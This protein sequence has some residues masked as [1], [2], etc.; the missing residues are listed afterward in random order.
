MSMFRMVTLVGL[1]MGVAA[2]AW[3]DGPAGE[4]CAAKLNGD[5]KAVYAATM[6]AKP[7]KETLRETVE[8]EARGLAMGGKIAMGGARENAMAAG[9]CAKVTLE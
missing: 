4:A 6:A 1:T 3:A 2:S 8:K 7:T 9:E 5:G